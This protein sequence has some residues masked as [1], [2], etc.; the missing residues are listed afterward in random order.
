VEGGD[1]IELAK[2]AFPIESVG[3]GE[4]GRVVRE[5]DVLVAEVARGAG[6]HVDVGTAIAPVRMKVAIALE[7]GAQIVTAAD[8]DGGLL[9]ELGE[10][11]GA[12]GGEDLGDDRRRLRPDVVELLERAA[13]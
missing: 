10:I 5:D 12:T 3:N 4:A 7:Q 1:D 11:R 2:E 8:A 9:F 6:H 13:I